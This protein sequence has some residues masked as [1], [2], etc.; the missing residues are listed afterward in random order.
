MR[1][2]V[3]VYTHCTYICVYTCFTALG[4]PSLD[5]VGCWEE[6]LVDPM[7]KDRA[8]ANQ[9]AIGC[10]K[11]GVGRILIHVGAKRKGG[12]IQQKRSARVQIW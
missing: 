2:R 4:C 8:A 5:G 10:R 12:S 1:V 9:K 6:R 3:C 7:V 11:V